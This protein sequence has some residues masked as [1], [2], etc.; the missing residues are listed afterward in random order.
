M[1]EPYKPIEY[2]GPQPTAEMEGGKLYT[3]SCHCGALTIAV[4]S[5]PLDETYDKYL[6]SCNCSH[7]GR[8]DQVWAFRQENEVVLNGDD[9]DLGK[10]KFGRNIM[11]KTFCKKCGVQM[12][13][14]QNPDITEEIKAQ[15]DEPGKKFLGLSKGSHNPNLRVLDGVDLSKLKIGETDGRNEF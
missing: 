4:K 3:G 7:C 10:Y 6:A 13:N 1:G 5:P 12:T 9:A 14:R 8:M 15:L 2:T 11:Q